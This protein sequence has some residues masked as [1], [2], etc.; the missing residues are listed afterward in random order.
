MKA[1]LRNIR[2][3]QSPVGIDKNGA[4]F[5][6]LSVTQAD[7]SVAVGT[8]HVVPEVGEKIAN[9][10]TD[11]NAKKLNVVVDL[12]NATLTP[13]VAVDPATGVAT[14]QISPTG[15]PMVNIRGA[16]GQP[17]TIKRLADEPWQSIE[18]VSQAEGF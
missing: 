5:L 15:L 18:P 14:A 1:T 16:N 10:C 2:G 12:G 11:A 8:L 7:G 4:P 17:V 9:A 3:T 6:S 13:Q